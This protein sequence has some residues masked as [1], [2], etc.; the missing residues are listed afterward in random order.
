MSVYSNMKS[1]TLTGYKKGVLNQLNEVNSILP[2]TIINY[3]VA[4]YRKN[5]TW[6]NENGVQYN[7]EV[8]TGISTTS[9]DLADCNELFIELDAKKY[10]V[11][12][13]NSTSIRYFVLDL[14]EVS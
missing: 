4:I 12:G 14:E 7:V 9:P 2:K 3:S 10:K 13:F 11:K 5:K 6:V 1:A 8:V